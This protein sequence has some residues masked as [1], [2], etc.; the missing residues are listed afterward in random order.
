LKTPTVVAVIST[1][2]AI[3]MFICYVIMLVQSQDQEAF[4]FLFAVV[5]FGLI[6]VVIHLGD[7]DEKDH[8]KA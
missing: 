6:P 8:S 5:L 4:A 1:I 2:I 3:F 7:K